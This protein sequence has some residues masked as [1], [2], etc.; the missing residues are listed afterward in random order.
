MSTL[1]GTGDLERSL[2]P[3]ATLAIG[4]GTMV[5]AG[6][7]VFPGLA[8]GRA[9]PA[10]TLSFALGAAIALLVALPTAELATAMPESGG[11]YHYVSRVMGPLAGTVVGIAQWL[12]LVFASAFYPVG[13]GHYFSDALAE[14]GLGPGAPDSGGYRHGGAADRGEHRR[15]PQG[16]DPPERDRHWAARHP[17]R[18]PGPGRR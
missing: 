4:V 14:T 3:G 15:Y 1:D 8:A 5:G 17:R 2:G 10:A 6:I 18:V 13:V 7:F 11:V 9:G 12:G 16:R